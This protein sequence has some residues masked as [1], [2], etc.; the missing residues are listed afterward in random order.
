MMSIYL[1]VMGRVLL[2]N[3]SFFSSLLNEM[4]HEFNQEVRVCM[5]KFKEVCDHIYIY[6][7]EI[8]DEIVNLYISSSE[9]LKSLHY[10]FFN[11]MDFTCC[12]G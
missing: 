4:G 10:T 12:L 6:I 7:L 3:T 5:L 11:N 8:V 2:Q 9:A 1:A